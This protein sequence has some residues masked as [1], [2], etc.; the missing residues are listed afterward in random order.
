MICEFSWQKLSPHSPT[1][2]RS[3]ELVHGIFMGC[4]SQS[5]L[6]D[7]LLPVIDHCQGRPID[8]HLSMVLKEKII[9]MVRAKETP[10]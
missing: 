3:K 10:A 2:R 9:V 4:F 7:T 5:K 1:H 6:S 8:L